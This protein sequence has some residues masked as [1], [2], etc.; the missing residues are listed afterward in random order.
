MINQNE[1]NAFVN[2]AVKEFSV[3]YGM[4]FAPIADPVK[5][6]GITMSP[7]K[8]TKLEKV[9][10]EIGKEGTDTYFKLDCNVNK[11][12]YTDPLTKEKQESKI[13]SI[14]PTD[15]AK[16]LKALADLVELGNAALTNIYQLAMTHP[17]LIAQAESLKYVGENLASILLTKDG[18]IDLNT[19]NK[20]KAAQ[21]SSYLGVKAVG[22][23]NDA[24]AEDYKNRE[25]YRLQ[26]AIRNRVAVKGS[27]WAKAAANLIS[28]NTTV[29]AIS[30]TKIAPS[31]AEPVIKVNAG[32]TPKAIESNAPVVNSVE[33]LL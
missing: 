19:Y 3:Q 32:V 13:L 29:A 18:G 14:D 24:L 2:G 12:T 11:L 5:Q 20:L 23:A 16:T 9:N 1:L 33:T 28:K 31:N 17:A 15:L 25:I 7:T 10:I 6:V 22:L 30:T 26:D 27:A 21:G 4:E 8:D